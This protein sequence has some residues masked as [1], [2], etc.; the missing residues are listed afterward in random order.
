MN[1]D[2]GDDVHDFMPTNDKVNTTQKQP[3]DVQKALHK[4]IS[5]FTKREQLLMDFK[6]SIIIM[7]A[8]WRHI[9]LL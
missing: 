2:D 8:W 7:L 9:Y 6:V 5:I 1:N 3:D 4:E